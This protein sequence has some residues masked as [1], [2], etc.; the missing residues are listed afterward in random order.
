MCH[1]HFWRHSESRKVCGDST[2]EGK[3]H[4]IGKGVGI[5]KE[6]RAA[7]KRYTLGDAWRGFERSLTTARIPCTAIKRY[8]VVARWRKD[9]DYVAAGIYCFQPH[10]VT[11]EL[12]PPANPLICPQFCLRFNDLDNI[13]IS[14][15][16]FSGFIMLGIQVFNTPG[17]FVFFKDE[18]V[19]F[20]LRWLTEELK[21]DLDE[22]TLIEDVWCGGGNLG[23]SIEYFV[24]GLELGNM[25]FMQYK[26]TNPRTGAYE[27]LKVQVI[28]V[29][30]GLER[31]P[32]LING[33]PTSYVDA[34]PRAL[35]FLESRLHIPMTN[36]VIEKFGPYS[37]LLNMDE[38]DDVEQA[39]AHIC[40][41]IGL[42]DKAALF[43]AIKDARDMY[44]VADHT[45]SILVAVEDGSLPSAIGGAS[46]LRNIIRRV[47]SLLA[48]NGWW[49]KFGK[50]DKERLQTL[51]A[52]FDAHREDLA[53]IYGPPGPKY[54]SF[55]EIISVEYERWKTTDE[56]A[57]KLVEQYTKRKKGAEL[58]VDDWVVMHKSYGISPD[59]LVELLK[60]PLP[61]NFFSRLAEMEDQK[62]RAPPQVLYDTVLLDPT[63]E[64]F[65]PHP[66]MTEFDAKVVA[67]LAYVKEGGVKTGERTVV[68][69]D[70]TCFYPTAGGQDHDN[71]VLVI[72]GA[73]YNVVNAER[74][75][76][77]V[78]HFVDRPV[79]ESVA[80]GAP[81][82][83]TIDVA[84]RTVLRNH[85]TATHIVYQSARRILGPHV[86]QHGA[87]KTVEEAHLDI[88]HFNA[89]T[90]EQER[91]IETEANRTI[92]ANYPITKK[93]WPKEKA[94]QTYGYKLYQGGIAPGKMLRVVDIA[95]FDTEACCGTHCDTTG[96]VGLVRIIRSHRISDGIVRLH[97]V[98]GDRALEYMNEECT[99]LNALGNLW[100]VGKQDIIATAT[101]F[102]QGYKKYSAV[103]A[104]QA[105]ELV[106]LQI[107]AIL[108][109][110]A[111]PARVLVVSDEPDPTLYISNVKPFA[112]R[113]AEKG[114]TVLVV[115]KEFVWGVGKEL[116]AEKLTAAFEAAQVESKT[117]KRRAAAA[118]A[119]APAAPAKEKKPL[120][121]V[122]GIKVKVVE[123]GQKK[124][125]MVQVDVTEV[126]GSFL[127]NNPIL[128]L[129]AQENFVEYK[130]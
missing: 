58:T 38:V 15:R 106:H 88:T 68:V 60:R 30:I 89:L 130:F 107:R 27:P 85:H 108:S 74:V 119:A 97:F 123:P 16:H 82:H 11:G 90:F 23:P 56:K 51:M 87:K 78:L 55:P 70:R 39:Y 79:P 114:K 115:G 18:C 100:G 34:F 66:E 102:F 127:N 64:L 77:C 36:D 48:K 14:G 59:K 41:E 6:L 84:R 37:C 43:A 94:E 110:E 63:E 103:A 122:K 46:N 25:V 65:D 57:S 53:E 44:I 31:I 118:S 17:H 80:R 24:G 93:W 69:L 129:A 10:C 8:P 121:V 105:S 126:Q 5:G 76:K 99:L 29:G 91:A 33:T 98:A 52:L 92:R 67:V 3:Y 111:A 40:K 116:D 101:R 2:C 113:L 124:P 42:K 20:N 61:D 47:F 128:E 21:I 7:G 81:V 117:S 120:R 22:I 62:V 109:D 28:D 32:W 35:A 83:G 50:D 45:R 75:G 9:V 73:A 96:Q 112:P 19:E 12:E 86:W 71:G 125:K 49:E 26:I 4:F 1:E 54:T 13:G 104:K 95:G 72:D